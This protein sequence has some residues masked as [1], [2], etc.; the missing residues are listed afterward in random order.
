MEMQEAHVHVLRDP[1]VKIF[2]GSSKFVVFIN[3]MNASKN[4]S[5]FFLKLQYFLPAFVNNNSCLL[6]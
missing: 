4:R 6:K 1:H 3:G 5:S 2:R